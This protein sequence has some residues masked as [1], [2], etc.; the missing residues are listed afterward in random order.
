MSSPTLP[1][2]KATG[3]CG[4]NAKASNR[5]GDEGPDVLILPWSVCNQLKAG[6][7]PVPTTDYTVSPKK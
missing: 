7:K 5:A 6:I 4:L 2:C 3:A 1:H